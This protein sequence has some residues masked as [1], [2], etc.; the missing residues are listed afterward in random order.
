[1]MIARPIFSFK[2]LL[3]IVAAVTAAAGHAQGLFWRPPDDQGSYRCVY[4]EIQV[5]ATAPKS[6]FT[7]FGWW[8]QCP[9]RGH[10]ALVDTDGARH[11]AEITVFDT[12]PQMQTL[13]V[14]AGLQETAISRLEGTAGGTQ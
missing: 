11:T 5:L 7:G 3:L 6:K 9:A 8:V 4:G 1:M 12:T 10:M 13:A 14:D 2:S